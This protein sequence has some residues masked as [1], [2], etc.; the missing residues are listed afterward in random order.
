MVAK[1][2][3]INPRSFPK[4]ERSK[5]LV[6]RILDAAARVLQK[7]GVRGFT[8]NNVA[9][10]AGVSIGSLYQYFPG[11]ESLLF[12]LHEAHVSKVKDAVIHAFQSKSELPFREMLPYLLR[13]FFENH[14]QDADLHSQLNAAEVFY[15]TKTQVNDFGTQFFHRLFIY[16]KTDINI[17]DLEG[18]ARFESAFVDAIA[19]EKSERPK[20]SSESDQMAYRLSIMILALLKNENTFR[21]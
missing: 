4:Q 3:P 15:K 18:A 11:K 21:N 16:Y 8:T 17:D 13:V 10:E 9:T 19:H 20:S 14:W 12:A 1:K 7:R 6:A 5:V 2:K